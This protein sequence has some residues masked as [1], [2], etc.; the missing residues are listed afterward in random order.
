MNP[1]R[2]LTHQFLEHQEHGLLL[3]PWLFSQ[4]KDVFIGWFL[5]RFYFSFL[6][7]SKSVDSRKLVERIMN[8]RKPRNAFIYWQVS[9]VESLPVFRFLTGIMFT[10]VH[11]LVWTVKS[12]FLGSQLSADGEEYSMWILEKSFLRREKGQVGENSRLNSK[13]LEN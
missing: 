11:R 1:I 7:P 12:M 8:S 4:T 6:N 5:L 10:I 3:F 9:S 13:R 2:K